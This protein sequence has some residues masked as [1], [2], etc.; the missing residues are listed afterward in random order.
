[1]KKSLLFLFLF[2]AFFLSQTNA[3]TVKVGAGGDYTTLKDAFYDINKGYLTG[4]VVIEIT[5]SL[6]ETAAAKLTG[7]GVVNPG[8]TS[9]YTS[10]TVYPTTTG[11]SISGNLASANL[12]DLYGADNVTIDGRVNAT[13]STASLT[14]ENTANTGATA[15]GLSYHAEYN[16]IKFCKLKGYSATSRGVINLD[17]RS[18]AAGNGDSHNTFSNNIFRGNSTG[19]PYFGIY[20]LGLA[21]SPSI[22][23]KVLNNDFPEF[24]QIGASSAG[25]KVGSNNS[26][27]TINANNFYHEVGTY[28]TTGS[29]STFAISVVSGEGHV[30]ENNYIGGTAPQCGGTAMTKTNGGDQTFAGIN[31]NTSAGVATSVQ[32]NVVKNID[33]SNSAKATFY[34]IF[35]ET[36]AVGDV[37]IGTNSGNIIG[38]NTGTGSINYTADATGG[39]V[40]GIY[41]N[42]TGST[43]CKYNQ[44]GSIT[45]NNTFAGGVTNMS[46]IYIGSAAGDCS[47]K[48]NTIGSASTANSI[49]TSAASA[50]ESVYG[51]NIQGLANNIISN[52]IISNLAT[53]TTAS[54]YAYGIYLG[55]GTNTVNANFIHSLD[56]SVNSSTSS[57]SA[58]LGGIVSTKGANIISNNIVS[59][60]S[61][62][63]AVIYGL[64]EAASATSTSFIHNSVSISG[65]NPSVG[66]QKSYSLYSAGTANIRDFRNNILVNTRTG[67]TGVKV[68]AVITAN[69]TGTLTVDKNNFVPAYTTLGTN[70]VSVN[71]GF[72]NVS[73]TSVA[74]YNISAS[75]TGATGTGIATDFAGVARSIP[76]MG[77]LEIAYIAPTI[78]ASKSAVTGFTYIVGN[79]P[80]ANQSF[81]VSG[82][83]LA[84]NILVTASANYEISLAANSG[85][86]SSLSI[87][88]IGNSVNAVSVY[89]RLKAQL[90][91]G[92]YNA[93]IISIH[94]SGATSVNIN[95][96]GSVDATP[97]AIV[98][99]VSELNQFYYVLGHGP[100]AAQIFTV[101]GTHLVADVIVTPSTNFEISE[102]ETTGYGSSPIN[103]VPSNGTVTAK[104]IYVRLKA[105]LSLGAYN[106]E[107]IVLSTSGA[108]SSNITCSGIVGVG[109]VF[110]VTVPAGTKQVYIA[111][112]FTLKN[113]DITTPYEL[114]ATG[115]PNQFTGTFICDN[116]ITYK[117]FCEKGDYDYQAATGGVAEIARTYTASDI[118]TAWLNVKQVTLNVSFAAG[119]GVPSQLFV[120]GSWDGNA[121]PLELAGN[122]STFTKTLGGYAGDKFSASTTYKYYTNAQT[123]VNWEANTNGSAKANRLTT[124]SIMTDIIARFTTLV[125]EV[126]TT[127]VWRVLPIR[128]QLEAARDSVGGEGEQIFHGFARCLN[129]PEYIYGCH[130]VMGSWRSIDGGNTWKKN[131]D[132]GSWLPFTRSIEVDPVNPNLVF[133]ETNHSWWYTYPTDKTPEYGYA[134]TL[135]LD[136]LYR[137]TDG[138]TNWEQVLNAKF[139]NST[140]AMRQLIAYS[141]ASMAT[142]NTSPTRWYSSFDYNALY[143]SDNGGNNGTW[144]KC[145]LIDTLINN[146][147][148]HPT[149]PDVVYVSTFGGL[150]KSSNAGATLVSDA[151]FAG[152]NVTSVLINP[153]DPNKMYVV[154]YNDPMLPDF[155]TPNPLFTNNGMYVST[156]G[157][158]NFTRPVFM[159]PTKPGTVVTNEC[160]LAYMNPGFPEQIYWVSGN[161]YGSLTQVT[162]DGGISWSN[163]LA[164]SITFPG[165]ERETGWR[166][167]ITG[168]FASILPNSKDKYAPAIATGSST[169]VKIVD[170]DKSTPQIIE[171]AT[172]FTGN[173]STA[174]SDAIS[175]HPNNPDVVM[176]SCNDIGPRTSTTKGSWFHEPDPAMYK[177]WQQDQRIG[178]AGSYSADY[179]YA[180]GNA[181]STNVVASVGMYNERAQ[182]MHSSDLGVTWDSCVTVLPWKTIAG[183]DS[184]AMHKNPITNVTSL[185]PVW[186]VDHYKQAFLFV[187]FD[188]E[189]GYENYC[190]SGTMMSTDG[191]YT[192]NHINFPPA[193]YSGTITTRNSESDV[194]PT[195][196]GISKSPDGKSHIIAL[197][198]FKSSVWRSDDHGT[199]WYPIMPKR[200]PSLKGFDRT[201]AFAVHP[202]DPNVFFCMNPA[203]RDL[204]KVVYNPATQ[205][206]TDV[207][208]P[209]FGFFSA[210]IPAAVKASNQIRFIAV[211]PIDPNYIYVSMSV[212]GI[213][214]V[215]RTT[216]GGSTWEPLDGITCHEGAMKVNP[217][218]RELY[219]GSMAGVWI[220]GTPQTSLT[221]VQN[222]HIVST[223]LRIFVDRSSNS[224][225]IFGAADNERFSIFDLSGRVLQQFV[226]ESTS[227]K[228]LSQGVFILKSSQHQPIKF[229]K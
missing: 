206:Y 108:N 181:S 54:G 197:S 136:G 168:K 101:D 56:A 34:G 68:A 38:S 184:M 177:W 93:D 112:S 142:P 18:A 31:L 91:S 156:D 69:A 66:A 41:T 96:N 70:S 149:L 103:I 143:R 155:T 85:F 48:Y 84:D 186:D 37:N 77:A 201:I 86:S 225:R 165:L 217:Y 29:F 9:N 121:V 171:S 59:I 146:V 39:N 130:D 187:G 162:N 24:L 195:V 7:S 46:A 89:V 138:G 180:T 219:R 141:K 157:G 190:Y 189:V 176:F 109:K 200:S 63:G 23:N 172:G 110:T 140:R 117:Y 196:L 40:Y 229:L 32:G 194:L 147:V 220:Y 79:G 126:T 47:I 183:T 71:P 4:D 208:L 107:N 14:I 53:G 87:A 209:I 131:L 102:S 92:T 113:W 202:T 27:W 137:S 81:T 203:T 8:G 97:P 188:P 99:S 6:T 106:G 158:I 58:I 199:S 204:M 222:T 193:S 17:N 83:N 123:N 116:S 52:N 60:K 224:L 213:P 75:L 119:T 90:I 98:T 100:S 135:L 152:D 182:L 36:G 67:G 2:L 35:I 145:A 144:V 33:W 210:N 49:Y 166:R 72:T 80:S 104:I 95:C 185:Q 128:S 153:Q 150:Y 20:A 218:T 12:I 191:G 57:S 105:G 134:G 223:K 173:S 11:L 214:N 88:P 76:K 111:G 159:H 139:D 28:A 42:T 74:D 179:Q 148:P 228:N 26:A 170:I 122:G 207:P 160:Q 129:H 221:T 13:G 10:V 161:I 78:I 94:S 65:V 133:M 114:T 15:I 127:E 5:S 215:W 198:A 163:T 216:N 212:S 205:T 115:T 3:S 211:D 61:A 64:N 178:W 125:P 82:N 192:F 19:T 50:S 51:V 169:I 154:V 44:I 22:D 151:R 62:F 120:S 174:W 55:G 167:R 43:V 1:M 73:G 30:I 164:S 124:A 21:G 132:N 175:F 226:G 25:V 227:L 45:G 16:T 118:V